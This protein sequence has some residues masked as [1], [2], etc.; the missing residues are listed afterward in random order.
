[1]YDTAGHIVVFFVMSSGN[2]SDAVSDERKVTR[3]NSKI[4][5][6]CKNIA[7]YPYDSSVLVSQKTNS[8]KTIF[9]PRPFALSM[10]IDGLGR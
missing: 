4:Q 8:L 5:E 9:R 6:A 2:N 7:A 3:V 10:A 1:M